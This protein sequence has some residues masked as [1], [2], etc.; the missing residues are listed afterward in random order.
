MQTTIKERVET[1]PLYAIASDISLDWGQK[2]HYAAKPYVM[3]MATMTSITESYFYDTGEDIVLRFLA[4]AS[5]WK[6][7]TARRVKAELKAM[8]VEAQLQRRRAVA[9]P[10]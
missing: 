10:T 6:G 1:R 9:S 5:S 2:M 3:A 7:E 4:N 8:C